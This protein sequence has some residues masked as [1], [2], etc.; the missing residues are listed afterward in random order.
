MLSMEERHLPAPVEVA[1]AN[2]VE[3]FLRIRR[4]ENTRRAYRRDICDF[5]AGE[6]APDDLTA[7][8]ALPYPRAVGAVLDY[9]ARLLEKG[10]APSTINR[11]MAA[12]RALVDLAY[13]LGFCPWQLDGQAVAGE[14]VQP[15]RDTTGITVDQVK[16]LLAVPNRATRKGRR[17]YAL[18]V[19][20]WEN[21]LR[22]AEVCTLDIVDFEAADRRLWVKGKG[23]AQ[24]EAVHLSARS[25]LAIADYLVE[26]GDLA[27]G[28]PLFA[29]EDH[30]GKGDGRLTPAGLYSIVGKLAERAGISKRLSPHRLRHTSITAALDASG[31]DVRAVRKLSRHAK[32]ETLMVYDDNRQQKQAELTELLSRIS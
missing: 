9:K 26:R 19:L 30:S 24:K 18:L 21:A 1:E 10:L 11:R 31:G 3:R 12:L 14:K 32:I 20:L 6:P 16:A 28:D 22:R 8:F 4:S 29:S 5:F 13:T 23:K 25:T 27:P 7:F 2:L 17:D 15:Y